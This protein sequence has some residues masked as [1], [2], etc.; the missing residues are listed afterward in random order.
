MYHGA[1][2]RGRGIETLIEVIT[3]YEDV[4][5]IILGNAESENYRGELL[6]KTEMLH[7]ANK[8][9]FREAVPIEELW[10]Y[11]GAV[12]VSM[13]TISPVTKS[14]Y[15]ALPN[16]LFESIQAGIPIIASDLPEM[17]K[18][19]EKYQ[20]GLVCIPDDVEDI[21]RCVD[22][23]QNNAK[24]YAEFKRNL[25]L[26]KADLCWEQEKKILMHS[27]QKILQSA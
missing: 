15:Y 18:I 7:T 26:A 2:C 27:Y 12:D 1:V 19:V 20:I 4:R 13:A 21:C 8:V 25:Q 11:I 24:Q 6:Q 14:Y 17:K 22:V 10:K 16:K 3:R 23:M 5:L 9:L